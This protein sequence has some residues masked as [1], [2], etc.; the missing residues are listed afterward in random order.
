M[1]LKRVQLGLL[2]VAVAMT[3]VPINSTLNR[4]MIKELALSAALVA[5][6][7]SLPYLFSPVQVWIGAFSDRNP[8]WGWR[9]TPYILLGL[10]LCAAGVALSPQVAFLLA[11]QRDLGILVGTLAF[12]AWGMGYN[13]AAVSYLSLATELSGPKGRSKTIAVMF[14]M[15]IVGIIFTSLSLGAMLETYSPPALM[16]AFS[17]V[18]GAAFV[19]GLL[20]LIGLEPRNGEQ[21]P[22]ERENYGWG[23]MF[24]ALTS[25]PQATRFFWYLAL[26]LT[27]ILG[28]DILLEP[29]GAEAFGMAVGETTRITSIWGTLFLVALVLGGALENRVAK[30][31]QA[32]LGAWL[33]MLAFGAIIASAGMGSRDVFYTGVVLLGFATGLST[34][35][36]LSLM[37]D[38][39]TAGNVGLFIGAWG[40]ANAVSRLAGNMLSGVVRDAVTQVSHNGALGYTVVFGIE[41]IMLLASLVIL[42]KVDVRLFQQ[43][44]GETLPYV[45]RAAMASEG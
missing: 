24:R 35:S 25:N 9:R 7:A 12:G 28:Q 38:M 43:R 41:I 6:L 13:L 36:N 26:L 1:L 10:I 33:G 42:R 39:T 15:M 44:A 5:A 31:T 21:I 18:A 37:L 22:G 30:M 32:R 11:E 2:H 17:L 40:M 27:A 29:F 45:E 19:L 4:V 20:G 34:V 16:R 14:F 23:E 8:V 3:L